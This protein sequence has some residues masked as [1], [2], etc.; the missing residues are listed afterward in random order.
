MQAQKKNYSLRCSGWYVDRANAT[1]T[2]EITKTLKAKNAADAITAAEKEHETI[3][4]KHGR[5]PFFTLTT[6]VLSPKKK[7]IF[8]AS[9]G[10]AIRKK[11]P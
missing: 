9:V 6:I 11:R 1:Q 4:Q 7:N 8:T 10:G 2:I 5:M 3:R